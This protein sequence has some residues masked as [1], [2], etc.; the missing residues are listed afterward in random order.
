[1]YFLRSGIPF[2]RFL[3]VFMVG[4]FLGIFGKVQLPYLLLF[5]C[6]AL[7][8]IVYYFE[9]KRFK[10]FFLKSTIAH[11][12]LILIGII[13][14]EERTEKNKTDHYLHS[15]EYLEL[16]Q[17]KI[18]TTPEYTSK[19]VKVVLEVVKLKTNKSIWIISTGKLI[20]YIRKDSLLNLQK[21]DVL[22]VKGKPSLP[23]MIA[24]PEQFDYAD[25]LSLKNIYAVHFF[26]KNSF[27]KIGNEPSFWLI[28]LADNFRNFCDLTLKE[29][30]KGENEYRISSALLLGVRSGLDEEI[31][32]AYSATGT[33]HALA[34]S[35]LHVSLIYF[36]VIFIFGSIKKVTY[37]KY[38]FA[39]VSISIFWFYALVT[40]FCPSVV[41]AVT[42]FSVFLIANISKRNSGI[43]NTLAFSAFIILCI[44]PFWLLDIGFQFSFLA[45][46][47]I[48]YIYPILYI[49]CEPKNTIL[50][51][52]WS[53]ICISMAAQIAVAPLS[54]YYFHSFPL[55]FLPFNMLIVPLSS[56]ALYTGLA[57]LILF[58]IKLLSS[59]AFLITEYLIRFMNYIVQVPSGSEFL[60]IEF[61]YLN[62]FELVLAYLSILFLFF[63]LKHKRYKSFVYASYFFF[64]FIFFICFYIRL[65]NE[66][67]SFVL[68]N[69]KA[70]TIVSLIHKGNAVVLSDSLLTK[71]DKIV[72]YNFYNYL[73]KERIRSLTFI[74]F[75]D[76]THLAIK[77]YPFGQF[78]VWK[79]LKI[80]RVE[81]E[82]GEEQLVNFINKIDI[83]IISNNELYKKLSFLKLSSSP[84][85]L[86]DSS[87]KEKPSEGSEG[88]YD[89]RKRGAYVFE[90]R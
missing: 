21:G 69:V 88:F 44:E 55:L 48:A 89:V 6:L 87:I 19:T 83:L 16:Y 43:F 37:G 79:G 58:K 25:Y 32:E 70:K 24:N 63:S 85:I 54:I 57:G 26:T 66:K 84:F 61:L 76:S 33:V 41:R 17:A 23:P 50:D 18:I 59:I 74:S 13:I 45:V 56:V 29:G 73:S 20:A 22:I 12:L 46:V 49:W 38:I 15:L 90:K 7:Y 28:Q 60:K 2:V 47:G 31:S 62:L 9:K 10:L 52:L 82:I 27:A 71:K 39:V 14:V 36:I 64:I 81:K 42:M 75:N 5:S 1:M 53:L 8:C 30:I 65:S 51:K 11:V 72:R 86:I 40:G 3:I 68:Y 77:Q 67:S 80:L 78:I 35:G 34:V 4:I